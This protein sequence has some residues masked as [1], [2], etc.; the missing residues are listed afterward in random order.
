MRSNCV[1]NI[2]LAPCHPATNDLAERFVQTFKHTLKSLRGMGSV[3]HLSV[4][5]SQ[6]SPCHNKGGSSNAVL[7]LI[8]PSVRGAVRESQDSQLL[9]RQGHS[10]E[11]QFV[12]SEPVL[13]RE[14]RSGEEKLD[15]RCSSGANQACVLQSESWRARIVEMSG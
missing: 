10:R 4:D 6:H 12:A 1:K 15:R 9:R 13:I 7:D 8:K 11:R 2:R 3:Q 14:Y 5:L